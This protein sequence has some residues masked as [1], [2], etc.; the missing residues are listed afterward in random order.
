M[1]IQSRAI[2]R[3]GEL[4]LGPDDP[5]LRRLRTVIK[6][7][8]WRE[9]EVDGKVI[10]HDRFIDFVRTPPRAGCGWEPEKVEALLKGQGAEEALLLWRRAVTPEVGVNQNTLPADHNDVM[11]RQGNSKSYTL[12][13]LEREAPALFGRVCAG[14]LSANAAAIEAGFRKKLTKYEQ[15]VAWLPKLTATGKRKLKEMLE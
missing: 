9:R 2:N 10:R 1:K 4:L 5:R 13:R 7:N 15:I 11:T 6:E 12:D 14:E 8:A 3:A